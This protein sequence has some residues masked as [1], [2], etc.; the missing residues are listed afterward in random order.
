MFLYALF[1]AL[2]IGV[3]LGLQFIAVRWLGLGFWLALHIGST[4]ISL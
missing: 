4:K 3:N 2:A 1:C